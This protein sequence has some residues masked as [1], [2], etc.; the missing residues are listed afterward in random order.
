MSQRVKKLTGLVAATFTPLTA[1]GEINLSVIAA[2]V[3]YLIEKQNVK[4]VFVNGTTG[5]G[6]SLTVD[7]RK[8]LAAAWCQHGKGKLEQLIVHVGCMSI[9]DSQE[10]ARHAASIGA[11]GISVISPSYFKPINADALRLFIKEVSASA[12]DLPMYYYHLPGMT[13]VALEAADVLNGI[14][15]EIP[16]F[17]GVKYSGTDLRDL[18]QCVCYSQ[19]RDWSVLYGVDEQLLGALVLG[20]H[21]AVGSTY[22][23][24][25]HIVNQMLSA[26]NNGNHTQT[27]DLQFGFMEV[28][29]FARTLGFDVSVN[30]QV[31]SEVSGLPM[32]PPRLPLLPCPVSKAQAIAQKIHNFTQGL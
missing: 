21:G 8:H 7:E 10:L 22:N 9:K 16:S 26:F 30:K 12:P 18:G 4:S 32:G 1:E 5:E 20:V 3:D 23:Y 28:I 2:Y 19:S 17:Q 11:D 13:G 31:M 15:R 27:R 24:L 6:C 14:E 29:T 25:G